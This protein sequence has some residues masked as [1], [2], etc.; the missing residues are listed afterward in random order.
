MKSYILIY[1]IYVSV[2]IRSIILIIDVQSNVFIETNQHQFSQ[3]SRKHAN[4]S[5]GEQDESSENAVLKIS[6]SNW[7]L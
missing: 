5:D 4:G 2:T 7:P 3:L 1:I 6:S